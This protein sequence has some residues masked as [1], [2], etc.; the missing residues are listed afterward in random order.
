MVYETVLQRFGQTYLAHRYAW[1]PQYVALNEHTN[2]GLN[3]YPNPVNG[4][5]SIQSND[6]IKELYLTDLKGSKVLSVVNP[7]NNQ[8]DVSHLS[9]G[10]YSINLKTE[11][12]FI[13]KKLIVV[14]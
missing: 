7:S 6:P 4:I 11:E 14:H 3:I 5:L 2:D 10:I 9:S 13:I 1:Y 8:F 12:N